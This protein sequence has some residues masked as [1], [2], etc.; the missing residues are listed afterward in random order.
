MNI[1]EYISTKFPETE[2]VRGRCKKHLRKLWIL[3]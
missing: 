1:E 3:S 2:K